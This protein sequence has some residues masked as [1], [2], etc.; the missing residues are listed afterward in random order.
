M[1]VHNITMLSWMLHRNLRSELTSAANGSS[2]A[3]PYSHYSSSARYSL[4]FIEARAW[5]C[6]QK[7]EA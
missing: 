5:A 1:W 2:R 6:I 3:V 7:T 4:S